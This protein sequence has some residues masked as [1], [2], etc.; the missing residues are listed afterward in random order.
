MFEA[1]WERTNSQGMEPGIRGHSQEAVAPRQA[2][3]FRRANSQASLPVQEG[4]KAKVGRV[5]LGFLITQ[6]SAPELQCWWLTTGI[7]CCR[8]WWAPSLS[9]GGSDS[10]MQLAQS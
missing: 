9:P 4:A 6:N 10:V 1:A 2:F 3:L 5:S 8:E 7:S